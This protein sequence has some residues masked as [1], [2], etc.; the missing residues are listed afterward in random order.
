MVLAELPGDEGFFMID[1]VNSL[2]TACHEPG[3]ASH[4]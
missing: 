2:S 4:V 3:G 1:E